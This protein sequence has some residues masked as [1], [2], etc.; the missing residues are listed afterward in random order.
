ML[1]NVARAAARRATYAK[2]AAIETRGF[3]SATTALLEK[4]TMQV[5]SMGDSITEVSVEPHANWSLLPEVPL[6]S[7]NHSSIVGNNC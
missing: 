6:F 1:S 7:M 4:H 5:P 2:S 3:V